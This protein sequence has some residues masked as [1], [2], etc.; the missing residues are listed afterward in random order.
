MKAEFGE[1]FPN[2][3]KVSVPRAKEQIFKRIGTEFFK[4]FVEY[5]GPTW[6]CFVISFEEN[7]IFYQG[8]SSGLVPRS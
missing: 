4:R 6:N 7:N 5:N 2:E 1:V 3:L 8:P